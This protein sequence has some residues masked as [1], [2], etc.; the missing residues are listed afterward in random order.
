MSDKPGLVDFT[1]GSGIVIF[2]LNLPNGL[3]NIQVKQE[4][5]MGGA[6]T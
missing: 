2:V 6:D 5:G 4:R 3:L 1:I